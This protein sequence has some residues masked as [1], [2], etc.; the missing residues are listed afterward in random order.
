METNIDNGEKTHATNH[1]NKQQ[2]IAFDLSKCSNEKIIKNKVYVTNLEW[3]VH[4]NLLK[5]FLTKYGEIAK[6]KIIR[7]T[8]TNKSKGFGF[9]EFNHHSG[10]SRLLR[11]HKEDLVLNGRPIN[12]QYFKEKEKKKYKSRNIYHSEP[13]RGLN[14]DYEN[15]STVE[16]NQ[17]NNSS[18]ELRTNKSVNVSELPYN[19]LIS[20]FNHLCLRDLCIVEQGKDL[21]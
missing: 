19:I 13:H 2:E 18:I 11:A 7:D 1:R 9:V 21:I 5:K 17:P 20:I 14:T 8:Q 3:S 4:E 6:C 15:V 12:V 16:Q 10:A